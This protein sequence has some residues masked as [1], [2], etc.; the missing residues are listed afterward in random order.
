MAEL[1]HLE[2]FRGDV[3]SRVATF[4]PLFA[5]CPIAYALNKSTKVYSTF[6]AIGEAAEFG[7]SAKSGRRRGAWW[8]MP[9]S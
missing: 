8:Y 7:S 4:C 9:P 6:V 1:L 3:K 5:I 2:F